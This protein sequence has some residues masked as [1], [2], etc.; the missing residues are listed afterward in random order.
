MSKCDL[1]LV[2]EEPDR[3][4]H[5]GDEVVGAAKIVV[6]KDTKCDK[7]FLRTEW[8]THGRGNRASGGRHEWQAS[9]LSRFAQRLGV[10]HGLLQRRQPSC[11]GGPRYDGQAD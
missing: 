2:F 6:N 10:R 3:T 1:Y 8:R 9:S 4:Y 5:P 11:F 7:I